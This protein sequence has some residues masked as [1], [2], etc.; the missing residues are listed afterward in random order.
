ME[1]KEKDSI[2]FQSTVVSNVAKSLYDQSTENI[3]DKI[4]VY[5]NFTYDECDPVSCTGDVESEEFGTQ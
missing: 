3:L 5:K 2:V 4:M 1:N